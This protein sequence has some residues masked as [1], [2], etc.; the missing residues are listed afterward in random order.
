MANKAA[1]ASIIAA[2]GV[3]AVI[4]TIAAVT[5]SKKAHDGSDGGSAMSTSIKLSAL[6]S[7]TLYP[8]KCEKSLSP[9]VNETSDPEEVL[10][11][12]LQV[13]MDEVAAA[14]ARYADVGKGA[15]DGTVTKSA[16]GE[17]KK[18]LDDAVGDLKDMAGLRA[19][20]VVSHVKDLRTWLSGVMT[21][22]YTCADGFDKPELK[23][24]MDKLLQNSTELSSNA[25]AIVTRVGEFLKGQ[26]SAQK[27]GTSIGAGS[28]RL[29]GWPAIISDAETR[30]RRL[31]AISGKLDEIASVRDASRRLLVETMDEIDQMSHDG[32]RRLDNFVFGDH[33]SNLTDIPS[34][35][36]ESDFV[37]RRL[38]SMS[39]DDASSKA[40][41]DSDRD[42]VRRRRRLLS[43]QLESIA[44]MSAQLNRRLLA[45]DVPTGDDMAGKKRQR[46]SNS[47]V[48]IN[49]AAA[50]AQA[51]LEEIDDNCGKDFTPP[52]EEERRAL[53][54]DVIGTI[55]DLDHKHHQRKMLT[56]DL[57][58]TIDDLDHKHH[59]R[60]KL[61]TFPEWVP[62]QARRLLQ[63]PGLQKPNAV[64][65]ADGSGNFKTI[66][67][68]VNAAPKKS[69]ARFVIY[70]KAGEYKEYV[71]IPKDVTN[72]F[73]FG[74]GPTK[75]RVVGD[76]SN[77]GGFATI[78]TRTFCKPPIWQFPPLSPTA[79]NILQH[80]AEELT[81][82]LLILDA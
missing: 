18:L 65:A 21:Y 25:L 31:L 3:V 76:K 20:Q 35:S 42:A 64:V 23:E 28:R 15:T 59:H 1:T 38:L 79:I 34:Q 61:L 4:G 32:S 39:F 54:S 7:S 9:V 69:T 40:T 17:C 81:L 5:A 55:E 52:E 47:L 22:I 62:A 71:T 53:T 67:E 68:A 11:A 60:R 70:V 10:K 56:T 2:V 75:T 82:L 8:T 33:F 44:D 78:A 29:L 19:D 41:D 12:S 16:I 48:M 51:Q 46:L 58:G 77:K 57:V 26:E 66:T 73:M 13:A 45:M 24:A 50:E 27:N 36:K 72:V 37:R 14:F 80:P 49:D 43:A 74:D 6:C 30:R 63:I